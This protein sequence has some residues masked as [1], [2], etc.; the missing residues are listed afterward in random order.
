VTGLVVVSHSRALADAAIALAAEM[1]HGS[2][3]RIAVAAGLD[4][5]TFGT[6]ATA[7]VEA[8]TRAD[9]GDGVVILM[10]LGSAVLSAEMAL[11]MVDPAVRERATLCPAPL[12]EGLVVAA[13]AAAGGASPAEVA[14]EA[15]GSLAAKQ[16][17]LSPP[18]P[19]ARDEVRGVSEPTSLSAV[20]KITNRHGLHA[21]PA[22]RLVQE[23]RLYDAR[24][25]LLN[26]DTGAGPVPATSLSR[27][28]TLGALCGHR[29]EVTATG[30]QAREAVD[31]VVALAERRFDESDHGP[32]TALST[33]PTVD[34]HAIDA[35]PAAEGR[36]L[37]GSPGIAI[38]RALSV[39][40]ADIEVPDTPPGDAPTEWRRIRGAVAE[41]RREIQRVRVAAAREVGEEDARIFDAHLMLIDDADLL[42]DVHA[43]IRAGLGAPQAWLDAI[44]A[45][46]AEFAG[47]HDPYLRARAADVH[48]VGQQV[49]RA[50]VGAPTMRIDGEGVLVAEDLTPA[51]VADL[52]AA[53][54]RGIVLA[55]GS[56]TGHSAI[57]ARSRAIP[58]VV[59]AGP[60][61]LAIP[62]GTT[63][64]LD[65]TT[66]E[67]FVDPDEA[68]LRSLAALDEQ[69]RARA[70]LAL[71]A[72]RSPAITRD[73]VEILVGANLGS[74]ADAHAAAAHGA[75]LA[76]LVRTEFLYLDRQEPPSVDEQ[77]AV[78]RALAAALSGKRLVL[79]TLD[80]G[81]DKPLGYAPQEPEANPFLGVRGI[82]LAL[83]QRQLLIDQLRAVVEVA[84]ET[85][86][87]LMFPMVSTVDELLE[88]RRLLEETIEADGRGTPA[89]L[90]VGIMVEV[91]AAALKTQ[92]FADHVDFFSIGTNDLT[93][94]ALAA[95]RGNPA[96]AALG[97][98]LDPGVLQLI[99]AVCRA[100]A[101]RCLVS[102]CGEL[103]ADEQAAALLVAM[104][105]R[106]LS[107]A[108][109][110]VPGVKQAVR[111][112]AALDQNLVR[113]CLAASGPNE[114]HRLLT[115]GA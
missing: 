104:G 63:I 73:D 17:H 60:P 34:Q 109:S 84:H 28:A 42:D 103:A 106:E 99:D 111:Q 66:G 82:R 6:D 30:S 74:V 7:I 57:L 115:A 5:T 64:A 8:I 11:D 112:I 36:G 70:S 56:P 97:D 101:G 37:P 47:V 59:A 75:D 69:A 38:G 33:A 16:S 24:I 110:S 78:Y 114:V 13:V 81:G 94:Y 80:V 61:V 46:E 50:L 49:A 54:V 93:Q 55:S 12:V 9:D 95:E 85:P 96:V 87:S 68:T 21:R 27:V 43:R 1:L 20:V 51:Q 65:G 98:P 41:V 83:A 90:Q 77:V 25:Q 88:V 29:V 10:D 76:G 35:A 53:R 92:A 2:Q 67:V 22:A 102:V 44:T 40:A 23:A 31:H 107:V 58:A 52:D 89:G 113:E 71:A 15:V 91:P 62:T 14:A 4:A 26:L 105:V 19:A 72:A 79:R 3:V 45:V 86:V 48:A 108:P 32:L 39:R 18:T 100:A